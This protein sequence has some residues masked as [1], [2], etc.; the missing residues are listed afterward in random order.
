MAKNLGHTILN[1]KSMFLYQAQKAF[2]I[3]HNIKPKIDE[4]L[5]SFLDNDQNSISWTDWFWKILY[6]KII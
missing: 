2:Q 4:D 1:G 6:F 3:W 5:I